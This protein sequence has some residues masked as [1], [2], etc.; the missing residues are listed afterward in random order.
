MWAKRIWEK[1]AP[2]FVLST[3]RRRWRYMTPL[4][5]IVLRTVSSASSATW[6]PVSSLVLPQTACFFVLARMTTPRA[7]WS[8]LPLRR[9]LVS[10][11]CSLAWRARLLLLLRSRRRSSL[12][13]FCLYALSGWINRYRTSRPML[14][15]SAP[16]RAFLSPL[17]LVLWLANNSR[18]L[19][20][21]KCC[22]FLSVVF[23]CFVQ[24]NKGEIHKR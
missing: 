10:V 23:T 3:L 14:R 15:V 17:L 13:L 9:R 16:T 19:I 6:S 7:L 18:T 4:S 1:S 24:Q 8:I 20:F 2:V 12:R 11:W 21:L 22:G 5:L